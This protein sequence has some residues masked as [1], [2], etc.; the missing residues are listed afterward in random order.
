MYID[1]SVKGKARAYYKANLMLF[2]GCGTTDAGICE[3]CHKDAQRNVDAPPCTYS[4]DPRDRRGD[5]RKPEGMGALQTTSCAGCLLKGKGCV[6]IVE[7]ASNNKKKTTNRELVESD[8][9]Y[10]ESIAL[11]GQG[12]PNIAETN[13]Y[14]GK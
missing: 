8:D 12:F 9:D 1:S 14:S 7:G 6:R 3:N 11:S 5:Y 4:F 13:L 2:M 10:E